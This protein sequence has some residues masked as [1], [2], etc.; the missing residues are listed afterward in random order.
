M[1]KSLI[2]FFE[3]LEDEEDLPGDVSTF[4]KPKNRKNIFLSKGTFE[5]FEHY[6]DHELDRLISQAERALFH[7]KRV[8]E[9]LRDIGLGDDIDEGIQ[10]SVDEE[11]DRLI[12]PILAKLV[13]ERERQL[14]NKI[15]SEVFRDTTIY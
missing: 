5:Q 2:I 10:D 6:L 11:L 12:L 4:V 15:N 13:K 9:Y 3:S 8:E 1:N 14:D 7:D